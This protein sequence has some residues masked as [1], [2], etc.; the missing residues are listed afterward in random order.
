MDE[1]K[2]KAPSRELLSRDAIAT[3]IHEHKK[4]LADIASRLGYSREGVRKWM[5]ASSGYTSIP[6]EIF[7]QLCKMFNVA[8]EYLK[9]EYDEETLRGVKNEQVLDG[10]FTRIELSKINKHDESIL[11]NIAKY[12]KIEEQTAKDIIKEHQE[13][14][15]EEKSNTARRPGFTYY[16]EGNLQGH[17]TNKIRRLNYSKLNILDS[18]VDYLNDC[19]LSQAEILKK[20]CDAV[21]EQKFQHSFHTEKDISIRIYSWI[22]NQE[23]PKMIEKFY[24]I[25][26][27]FDFNVNKEKDEVLFN[28]FTREMGNFSYQIQFNFEKYLKKYYSYSKCRENNDIKQRI[29]DHIHKY[30]LSLFF[31]EIDNF[32][33]SYAIKCNSQEDEDVFN[34]FI[35]EWDDL[36]KK[37]LQEAKCIIKKNY[38]P[39]KGRNET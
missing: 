31:L 20:F 30:D 34:K 33:A 15:I 17:V 26:C 12:F 16:D 32:L 35:N 23:I 39:A 14:I 22:C 29:H 38:S 6:R 19:N 27:K 37:T 5:T 36:R 21:K 13:F 8:P 28:N 9:G 3:L 11:I 18:I 7:S 24:K 25:I 1:K 4:T 2:Y 10:F